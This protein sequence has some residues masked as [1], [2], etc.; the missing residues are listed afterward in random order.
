MDN[1]TQPT[2]QTFTYFK[3][4]R[5]FNKDSGPHELKE[6]NSKK[7]KDVNSGY[8]LTKQE[9]IKHFNDSKKEA[10]EKFNIIV[11]SIR[12]LEKE[13]DFQLSYYLYGDT[14]GIYEDGMNVIF[15]HNGYEL[16]FDLETH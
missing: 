9:A 15:K 1:N 14:Y 10:E 6:F 11:K 4:T 5:N 8:F 12:A 3:M 2:T 16:S 13:L 7:E